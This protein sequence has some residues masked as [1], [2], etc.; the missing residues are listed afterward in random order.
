MRPVP[1][2]HHRTC[3]FPHPAVG[4]GKG[5]VCA[6]AKFHGMV[7]FLL[8]SAEFVSAYCIAC[9]HATRHAPRPAFNPSCTPGGSVVGFLQTPCPQHVL[10]RQH[11]SVAVSVSSLC[12]FWSPCRWKSDW[13]RA[14]RDGCRNPPAPSAAPQGW[15]TQLLRPFVSRLS[16]PSFQDG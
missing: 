3:G 2:P 16:L 8:A 14:R 13:S 12:I 15:L 5:H 7:N 9:V 1:L 11:S 10:A 4:H 6:L